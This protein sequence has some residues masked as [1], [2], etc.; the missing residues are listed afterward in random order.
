[1][2]H[3]TN[4]PT[5]LISH[6]GT[7]LTP[8][9]IYSLRLTNTALHSKIAYNFHLL[10]T[11]TKI[12]LTST[13]LHALDTLTQ[14][15]SL[16]TKISHL[17]IGTE[18]LAQ[19][20]HAPIGH[21]AALGALLASEPSLGDLGAQLRS[22]IL[23]R[24][25]GLKCI[26]IEDRPSYPDIEK[27]YRSSIGSAELEHT[28]GVDLSWNGPYSWIPGASWPPCHFRFPTAARSAIYASIFD[29]VRA[30]DMQGRVPE[31]KIVM[32]GY[33]ASGWSLHIIP[34]V[35]GR[36]DREMWE[37]VG[38]YLT[39]LSIHLTGTNYA[40]FPADMWPNNLR[41]FVRDRGVKLVEL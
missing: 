3:L 4:L 15:P 14:T 18:S 5:E 29:I 19:Y 35:I 39:Q 11:T 28:T 41:G 20:R 6:I 37:G 17:T 13:S 9:S 12:S 24:M 25:V 21:T 10:F 40:G 22:I 16:A 32:R 27:E 36:C 30:L 23:E 26:T 8:I 38:K 34:E 2:S 33:E 1:M 7:F 31:L